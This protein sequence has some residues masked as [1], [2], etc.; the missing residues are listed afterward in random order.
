MDFGGKKEQAQHKKP[1]FL[2]AFRGRL[3]RWLW[4]ATVVSNIGWWMYNAAAGWLMTSL[5][6]NPLMVSLVQAAAS[7]P[8]FLFGLPAG[9]LA[10]IIDKRRFIVALELLITLVSVVF[11]VL[12]S[13]QFAT[14]WTLLFFMFLS[15][16]LSALEGPAWQS[17]V[18]QLV[19]KEDLSAAVAANSVGINIS[20]T[21]GPALAGL[22]IAGLGIAAPFWLDA[23]SN[24]GVIAVLLWWRTPYEHLRT[25]PAER[26]RSAMRDGMRYAR[27]NRRLRATLFRAV[28][29]FLFASAYWALL[30]L[31]ARDQI[32]GGPELY[33]LLLGAIGS[34]AVGCAFLLGRLKDRFGANGLVMLGEAGTAT[35]LFL[36]GLS[37]E[38]ILAVC[39][40]LIA[41]VSWI[42]VVATSIC[43]RN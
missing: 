8:M 43:R 36:L 26:F 37:R 17:I 5:D 4:V 40:S 38:P 6:S 7:L 41:G 35:T 16:T 11:A 21:V 15:S 34:G 19:P 18:P 25:L 9:A 10:D 20:R 33:G 39:A 31:V 27:N 22:I 28:G 12:V 13:K 29:F 2:T 42:A 24:A 14:A 3:F 23:F 1:S 32:A 30:P